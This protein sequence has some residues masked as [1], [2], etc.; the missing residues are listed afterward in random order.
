MMN[1]MNVYLKKK[2][3]KC[4][5]HFYNIICSIGTYIMSF[6]LETSLGLREY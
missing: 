2:K 1:Y 5:L 6:I 4:V 3:Y